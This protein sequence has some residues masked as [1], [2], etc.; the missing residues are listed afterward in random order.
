MSQNPDVT[1]DK[2]IFQS[3][4]IAVTVNGSVCNAFYQTID[5]TCS[6]DITS[7]YRKDN[8]V[9]SPFVGLFICSVIQQEKYRWSYGR[10]PHDVKKFGEMVIKLPA[11]PTGDPDWNYMENY[12]KSLPYGDRL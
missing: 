3:P 1:L 10:K 2:K 9:I 5:Y 4:S 12:I 6:H 8:I 7:L 11:T